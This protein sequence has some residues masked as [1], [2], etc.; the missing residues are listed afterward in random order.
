MVK[1]FIL[2]NDFI[3]IGTYDTEK[4]TN[5]GWHYLENAAFM[6]VSGEALGYIT[7]YGPVKATTID[8]CGDIDIPDDSVMMVIDCNETNWIEPLTNRR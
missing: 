1:L 2:K 4:N 5:P 7:L 8:R 3:V 6:K